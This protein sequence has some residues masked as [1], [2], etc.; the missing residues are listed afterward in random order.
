LL[1]ADDAGVKNIA[2]PCISTGI[3]GCPLN[4]ATHIALNEIA[5][6]D[7]KNLEVC[8]LCCF[9]EEE[10]KVYSKLSYLYTFSNFIEFAQNVI[11]KVDN[12]EI[13]L[14]RSVFLNELI[15][16]EWEDIILIQKESLI[17]I[18]ISWI[19]DWS[20]CTAN[21]DKQELVK[22]L[23]LKYNIPILSID[24]FLRLNN[25]IIKN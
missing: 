14:K 10:Y 23:Y 19:Y 6:F 12:E 3:F 1:I 13:R 24:D 15:Q 25:K 2:F 17:H 4:E 18:P 5:N 8:Y 20:H 9:T 16:F 21:Y 11:T 22:G 7:A